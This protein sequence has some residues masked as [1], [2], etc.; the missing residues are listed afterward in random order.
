MKKLIC[1]LSLLMLLLAFVLPN[2]YSASLSISPSTVYEYTAI[3]VAG[4][5][6]DSTLGGI[7]III[8]FPDDSILAGGTP[9]SSQGNILFEVP[10]TMPG[11][12]VIRAYQNSVDD[13]PYSRLYL[14]AQY[15]F[16]V[17][18]RGSTASRVDNADLR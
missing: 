11:A 6:F 5:G 13:G 14:A 4:E 7:L 15:S 1:T 8:A 12:Y 2:A 16:N 17:Y 10:V 18:V 3:R 9:V